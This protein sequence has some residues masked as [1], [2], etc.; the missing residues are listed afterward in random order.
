MVTEADI[1]AV[2]HIL[3][4]TQFAYQNR[5]GSI[6]ASCIA[7]RSEL[8]AATITAHRSRGPNFKRLKAVTADGS[9]YAVDVISNGF[10]FTDL[11]PAGVIRGTDCVVVEGVMEVE[12]ARFREVEAS[13]DEGNRLKTEAH[14]SWRNGINYVSQL[15]ASEGHA[16]RA[17]LRSPQIPAAAWK[18][19]LHV[20][21][22]KW[23]THTPD[24]VLP[25]CPSMTQRQVTNF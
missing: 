9:T 22:P 7:R 12:N 25:F 8:C 18:S 2:T 10:D 1:G 17:G 4:P 23:R 19:S 5:D 15:E 21:F 24:P 6:N 13:L 14:A 11:A 16:A 3:L 20:S